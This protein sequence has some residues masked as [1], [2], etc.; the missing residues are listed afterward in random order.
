MNKK[1]KEEEMQG[2]RVRI[3]TCCADNP[4]S[5]SIGI[6]YAKK[7]MVAG[8]LEG[9]D[10]KRTHVLLADY[11]YLNIVYI[12]FILS[13]FLT[14]MGIKPRTLHMLESYH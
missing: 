1:G 9:D 8:T 7:L 13:I 2:W 14:V 6:T 12:C 11:H 4:S 10:T 5:L 3:L